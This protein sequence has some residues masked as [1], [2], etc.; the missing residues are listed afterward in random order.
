MIAALA[1]TVAAAAI[2][3]AVELSRLQFQR[4]RKAGYTIAQVAQ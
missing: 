4:A 2:I 1:L 3:G